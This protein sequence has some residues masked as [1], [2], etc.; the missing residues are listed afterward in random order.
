MSGRV[1]S[2]ATMRLA[3]LI[4]ACA[5]VVPVVGAPTSS[6][7]ASSAPRTA[8]AEQPNAPLLDGDCSKLLD[9]TM[10]ATSLGSSKKA[11]VDSDHPLMAI[12]GGIDC[13]YYV[14]ARQ[15]ITASA[16]V[17]VAPIAVTDSGAVE[18][19]LASTECGP[20][21]GGWSVAFQGCR[22]TATVD[23]WWYSLS[24]YRS[25]SAKAQRASF[26]SISATLKKALAATPAPSRVSAI[27]PFDCAAADTGGAPVTSSRTISGMW[28]D[29]DQR[30]E[31]LYAAAFLA[32]G[33]VTCHFTRPSGGAWEVT[34]YPG[35]SSIYSQCAKPPVPETPGDAS[36]IKIAGVK[37]AFGQESTDNGPLFCATDGTST[38]SV[39]GYYDYEINAKTRAFLSS[40]LVPVFAAA[41]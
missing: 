21:T 29:T 15:E 37:A 31:E 20:S 41:G 26:D 19:S 28:S 10:V 14:G 30:A 24:V 11:Q 40:I 9:P 3:A 17:T 36:V 13:V 12:V 8:L 25:S 38:V 2:R 35:S 32:A 23:G 39:S 34:V 5:L 6:A 16:S 22:S 7:E 4:T 27:M 1:S 18:R 33:P